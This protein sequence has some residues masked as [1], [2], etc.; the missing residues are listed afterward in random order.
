MK[1]KL[2]IPEGTLVE[3]IMDD[4]T[5]HR[6]IYF[7]TDIVF[8]PEK[9]RE[10]MSVNSGAMWASIWPNKRLLLSSSA[11]QERFHPDRYEFDYRG[12]DK[13]GRR[14]RYTGWVSEAIEYEKVSDQAADFFDSIID[15]MCWD[16]AAEPKDSPGNRPGVN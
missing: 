4:D 13:E 3:E 9:K 16:A 6:I 7:G 10:S 14:W 15:N 12:S 1:M 2:L 11:M 8:R 5:F